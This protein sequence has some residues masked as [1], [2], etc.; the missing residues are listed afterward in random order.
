MRSRLDVNPL[1]AFDADHPGT[2]EVMADAPTLLDRLD[3]ED[4]EHFADVRALLDRNGVAYDLD[5]TLV[6]GL[7]YYTR[8]VFEFDCESLGAQSGIG[9]GGSLRRPDRAA[10]RPAEE[11]RAA[12]GLSESPDRARSGGWDRTGDPDRPRPGVFVVAGDDRRDAALALVTELRRVGM[13]ADLDL[14]GRGRRDR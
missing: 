7:D 13:P 2:R 10:R 12:A 3:P 4:A 11:R 1:R 14:A 6:R 9:G 5:P 8:T